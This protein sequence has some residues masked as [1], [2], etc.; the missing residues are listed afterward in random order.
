MITKPAGLTLLEHWAASVAGNQI[1]LK[2][3]CGDSERRR[4]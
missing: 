2:I 4:A 3:D 1:G